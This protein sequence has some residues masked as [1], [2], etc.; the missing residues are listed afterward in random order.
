MSKITRRDFLKTAG[1]MTLA[2]AAAGVLA[3]CDGAEKPVAPETGSKVMGEVVTIGDYEFTVQ[4][5]VLQK[6]IKRELD[7]KTQQLKDTVEGGHV[8][9]AL[10]VRYTKVETEKGFNFSNVNVYING[11]KATNY[12]TTATLNTVE[13]AKKYMGIDVIPE[14]MPKGSA[15]T[16]ISKKAT[17]YMAVV[18]VDLDAYGELPA[19]NTVE[20]TYFD[21]ATNNMVSYKIPTPLTTVEHIHN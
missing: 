8:R 21:V 19:L 16:G 6:N 9:V 3:G 13:D 11:K 15:K 4:N 20:I 7:S 12:N 17:P 2:V 1:V 14:M 18:D 5:V 10:N